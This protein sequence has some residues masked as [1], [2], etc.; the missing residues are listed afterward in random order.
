MPSGGPNNKHLWETRNDNRA[1]ST[2]FHYLHND[3]GTDLSEVS[4]ANSFSRP[5]ESVAT[6]EE[7]QT[8]SVSEL[9]F[10]RVI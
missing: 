10:F 7:G 8:V 2:D 9:N 6:V 5:M 4:M 3:W 1:S